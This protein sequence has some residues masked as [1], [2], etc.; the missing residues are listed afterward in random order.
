M[1]LPKP[2]LFSLFFL[3]S[4]FVPFASTAQNSSEVALKITAI[5]PA[6]KTGQNFGPWLTNDLNDLVQPNYLPSN[7][8]YFDVVLPL[9]AK[10]K[11]TRVSL[12][13]HEKTFTD[14]PAYIYARNGTQKVLLGKFTGSSYKNWVNITLSTPVTADAIIVHKIWNNIPQ[15]VKVYGNPDADLNNTITPATTPAVITFASLLV[16]RIGDPAFLLKATSTNTVTPITF[17]SSN[18]AVA[19]VAKTTEGWKATIVGA[20]TANIT[21]S[22]PAGNGFSAATSVTRALMVSTTTSTTAKPAVITFNGLPLKKM[23]D[24]PF[25]ISATSTNTVTPITFKSSNAGVAS[26]TKTT[27]GWKITILKAGSVNITAQQAAGNGYAAA[28]SVTRTLVISS[29]RSVIT[30]A[31][32][33]P[34]QVGNAA[35][36]LQATSTN[37]VTPISF[38]SS[39]LAVATVAKTTEGWKATI[40]GA[41][42]ANITAYQPAGNG[43]M[44]A[45]N[46]VRSLVVSAATASTTKPATITF[47]ALPSKKV[48]DAAFLLQATSTNTVTP[49]TFTSSNTAVATVAKTTEGWKATIV[50]AGTANITAAQPAGNGYSAAPSVT[51][52]LVVGAATAVASPAVITFAALPSKKV[53]DAAFLVQATSTNTVTP[54]TLTSSNPAVATVVKATG[55]WKVTLVGA[56]T[57]NIT[58]A[59]PAGNGFAAAASVTRALVVASSAPAPAPTPGTFVTGEIPYKPYWGYHKDKSNQNIAGLFDGIIQETVNMGTSEILPVS[60]IVLNFPD[61]MEVELQKISFYDGKGTLPAGYEVKTFFIESGTGREIAG[62]EYNGSKYLAWIEHPLTTPIKVS[63]MI[64]RKRRGV[65]LPD[66][67]KL[68]GKYKP[69]T[70]PTFTKPAY[71]LKRMLGINTYPSDNASTD[72]ERLKQKI[73]AIEPYHVVRDYV[74]WQILETNREGEYAFQPTMKGNWRLDDIYARHKAKGKEVLVCIKNMP[75]WMLST[76]PSAI[77]SSENAPMPYKSS[78]TTVTANGTNYFNEQYNADKLKPESYVQIARLAFQFAARY[79][80]NTSVNPAL[81]KAVGS[82]AKIGLDLIKKIEANNEPDR[83]WKGRQGNQSSD[84]YAAYLSAFYDGHM[85]TLGPGVGVK[86]ADPNMIV[87]SGGIA[88]TK[89]AFYQGIVDWCKKNRGYLPNGKVNLCFD[90]INYHAYNNNFDGEQ[91]ADGGRVGVAPELSLAPNN[92]NN[93]HQINKEF[94]G[95]LPIIITETGYD[96]NSKTQGTK[97]IG[98]KD[99]FM[100]QGDWILRSSLDYAMAGLSGLYFYQLYDDVSGSITNTTQYATSGH[101]DRVTL[102][103]RP[104]AD[105]MA[106]VGAH[107]GDFVPVERLSK[108]PR[109]DKYRDPN[110]TTMYVGWVPDDK[111]RRVDYTLALGTDSAHV[112]SLRIGSEVMD[113][114]KVKTNNGKLAL[115]LTETPIFVVATGPMAMLSTSSSSAV[116]PTLAET[117]LKVYPNP[118]SQ[119]ATVEFSLAEAGEVVVDIYDSQGKLVKHLFVGKAE[120]GVPQTVSLNAGGLPNGVYIARLTTGK[121]VL[122]QKIILMN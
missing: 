13:D 105:Y 24:A 82:Q 116:V 93:F 40:V 20:G 84:E 10:S 75:G 96:W 103:R 92:I 98:S 81:V 52:A 109:V 71:P 73:A 70:P 102:A 119:N 89:T 80:S 114:R 107:F 57:A 78:Y 32:L 122:T 22:Q 38:K 19:T 118:F 1:N 101:V 63:A 51:R 69:Y 50:G 62:P 7:N 30:F 91:F 117:K 54:I 3:F 59:Q 41:G 113:V 83:H 47:A 28:P 86:Q 49:I 33:P 95:E 61:K 68:Y 108:D 106:Q 4:C 44:A 56:G 115:T 121:K 45:I 46:I 17:T 74:D 90:E 43:Y 5:Q 60:D 94:V 76:Y 111:D 97:V 34:K 11:V 37:T 87:V 9:E 26:V 31:S 79:G 15:K 25:S 55:G 112:Y 120:G 110:G 23:G 18:P 64:I 67:I 72:P 6:V 66:E 99:K 77:R 65:T 48:G 35:F 29:V 39:N 8:Q 104:A 85:G 12:Y 2:I 58:A 100:V 88:S 21:A 36:L 42:T 16:K 27:T 53:G 14:K